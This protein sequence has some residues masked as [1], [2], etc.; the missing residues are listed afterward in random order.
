MGKLWD[1]HLSLL[2]F[3]FCYSAA[4]CCLIKEPVGVGQVEM[5]GE[6]VWV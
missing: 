6:G 1:V 4:L 3:S 5:W 2:L